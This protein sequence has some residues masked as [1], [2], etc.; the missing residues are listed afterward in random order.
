[1]ESIITE[2]E[3]KMLS[4]YQR[5]SWGAVFAGW[6]VAVGFAS[7]M[8]VAGLALG[9]SAFDPNDGAAAAKG[10]SIATGVWMVLTWI[11]A[12]F[13]GGLFASW[14]DGNDDATMGA[15][16]G[17]TVWGLSIVLT[18]LLVAAGA[19]QVAQG[20]TALMLGH[21][22]SGAVSGSDTAQS[23][24]DALQ[25]A[26]LAKFTLSARQGS[27]VTAPDVA[28]MQ[29]MP[30]ADVDRDAMTVAAVAVIAN[31]P[32]TA[33]DILAA[34]SMLSSSQIDTAVADASAQVQQYEIQAKATAERLA[35][36]TAMT[37]WVAFVSSLLG[38]L[39]AALGGWLGGGRVNRVYHLRTYPVASRA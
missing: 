7:L 19:T 2:R 8:Y 39:A 15:L 32:Q 4:P 25:D 31:Q 29:P 9:F 13:L 14:F 3:D 1:M 22:T 5:M 10:F 37:M 35:H 6:V 26:L 33:K 30:L 23:P 36:Y 24:L 18:S 16:H 34:Q 12:L 28:G 11:G 38:M 21:A 17:V 27:P 20:G